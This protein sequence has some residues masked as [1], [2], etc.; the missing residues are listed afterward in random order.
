MI[1]RLRIFARAALQVVLVSSSSATVAAYIQHGGAWRLCLTVA[2][3]WLISWVW[4]ANTRAASLSEVDGG[5]GWYAA[6]AATGTFAGVGI[7]AMLVG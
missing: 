5:R 4:W 3:G 1:A 7:M 2:L 6:G